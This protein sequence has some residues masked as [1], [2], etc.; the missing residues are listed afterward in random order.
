MKNKKKS[1]V[2]FTF[3]QYVL[4]PFAI[5]ILFYLLA[6]IMLELFGIDIFPVILKRHLG[7]A[8]V[9][10]LGNYF[11]VVICKIVYLILLLIFAGR[12]FRRAFHKAPGGLYD[13]IIFLLLSTFGIVVEVLFLDHPN[14]L[15]L[16]IFSNIHLLGI[17]N[18]FFPL[19]D[20]QTLVLLRFLKI[21]AII[22]SLI[23]FLVN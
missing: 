7:I 10:R 11:W 2:W 19:K 17:Q 23:Y 9:F 21:S 14:S 5:V 20:P 18:Y 15:F 6:S 8:N 12:A 22:F 16:A 1:L 13:W 4:L 3:C